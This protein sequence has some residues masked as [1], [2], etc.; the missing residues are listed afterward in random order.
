MCFNIT[1]EAKNRS[2]NIMRLI[3][4][5]KNSIGDTYELY[6]TGK[7]FKS[8][9]NYAER[10]NKRGTMPAEVVIKTH[11]TLSSAEGSPQR[12]MFAAIML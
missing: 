11:R 12:R 4:T 10:K 2:D 6:S 9:V 8:V 3:E 5:I 1:T 7:S